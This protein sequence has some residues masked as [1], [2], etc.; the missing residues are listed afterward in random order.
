MCAMLLP[1]IHSARS[2]RVQFCGHALFRK[3]RDEMSENGVHIT[4]TR[5]ESMNAFQYTC[6]AFA[7]LRAK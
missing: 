1:S 5:L 3:E 2:A 4:L 6:L 7:I